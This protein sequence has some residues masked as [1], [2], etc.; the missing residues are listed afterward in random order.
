MKREEISGI[1]MDLFYNRK[2]INLNIEL[3]RVDLGDDAIYY[4]LEFE[5]NTKSKTKRFFTLH[6]KEAIELKAMIDCLIYDAT[7][8]EMDNNKEESFSYT[9]K[10][11]Q[12]MRK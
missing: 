11:C 9:D 4:E 8:D 10:K 5:D 1:D 7:R 12:E 3:V 6:L 2:K